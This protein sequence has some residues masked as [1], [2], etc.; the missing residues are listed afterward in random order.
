MIRIIIGF[1]L[2][3]LSYFIFSQ[4]TNIPLNA[5]YY[6]LLDRYQIK[7]GKVGENYQNT[8]RPYKREAV[9]EFL[10][11][12]STIDSTEYS[13]VDLFNLSYLKRDNWEWIANADNQS[14][15]N[16]FKNFY[17]KQ[18]DFYQVKTEDF[19]LHVNPVIYFGVGETSND[20]RA[21][22][23]NTRGIEVRGMVD[24]KI[25]FYSYLGENQARFPVYIRDYVSSN[26]VVP[27]EGFWK[28][29]KTKEAYDFFTARGYISFEATKH[30][31][32]QFGHDRFFVGNGYRS[33]ILSDFAPAYLFFKINTNIWK[34]QYTNLFTQMK[35]DAFGAGGG[36]LSGSRFPDKYVTFHHLGI[37]ITDNFN[38]GI[39]ESI[40]FG[41][42]DT[43]RNAT[44]NLNYL[45]P[46]IFYRAIEQQGGS[47]DNAILGLDF[48]WNL[49]RKFS[50]YGQVI[51]DELVVGEIFSGSG[52]WG[53]KQAVQLGIKYIDVLNL[54]NL[55]LQVEFNSVRPYTYS[56][57]TLFT[58]Y[59]HYRQPLAHPI[60]ANFKEWI[61]IL[62]YQPFNKLNFTGKII[63]N[64]YGADGIISNYGQNILLDDRTH[65]N[66]FGNEIGQG[67]ENELI[68]I[69][70]T[71]S[72]HLKQNLF[73]DAKLIYRRNNSQ[74]PSFDTENTHFAISLRL[75]IPQRLQEF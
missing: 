13:S 59:A 74:L 24:K 29:F 7:S 15:K 61:A 22:F 5:D 51:I 9:A 53:N 73:I 42:E 54:A 20:N 43:L 35:A 26:N 67:I 40:A 63:F 4:S 45:N 25:G 11:T 38:V 19:D 48:L 50:I 41:R 64:Q 30:I 47:I 37:N 27:S 1:H 14:R 68:F 31:N 12:I 32:F 2:L 62:R 10:S 39:F 56:H 17:K 49:Q 52:W 3:L 6:H 8:F 28:N 23:I 70:F 69:D 21:T 66:D 44:F 34:L 46:V 16:L 75:N 72:Y 55:D 65:L 33:L 71:S 36:S 18:S 60:G 57:E 58:N